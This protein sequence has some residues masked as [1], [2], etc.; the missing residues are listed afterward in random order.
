MVRPVFRVSPLRSSQGERGKAPDRICGPAYGEGRPNLE[1][2]GGRRDDVAGRGSRL[3]PPLYTW[4]VRGNSSPVQVRP[5]PLDRA[6]A[7][8][9]RPDQAPRDVPQLRDP[10]RL[11][12]RG[13]APTEG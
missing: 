5:L 3:P 8:R 4:P 13:S 11:P 1:G 2:H 12:P 7:P 10:S 9:G 6:G